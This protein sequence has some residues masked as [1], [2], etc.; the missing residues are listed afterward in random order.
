MKEIKFENLKESIYEHTLDNGL[1]IYFYNT[2]N[3]ARHYVSITTRYGSINNKYEINKNNEVSSYETVDG[4][5]HFLEH[6]L[7]ESS[8][9]EDVFTKFTKNGAGCNAYTSY[10]R[11]NYN[12]EGVDHIKENLK[13]LLDFV[14]EPHFT[15]EN[16]AKER[17][18]IEQEIGMKQDDIDTDMYFKLLKN[19]L[20]SSKEK[21]SGLGT[22]DDLNKI[23]KELLYEIYDTFYH[24]K[25][26]FIIIA[27][28]VEPTT[29]LSYVEEIMST[30]KFNDYNETKY[31]YPNE[32]DTVV[33]NI[34]EFDLE[35]PM[36]KLLYGI[37]IPNTLFDIEKYLV[38][39]YINILLDCLF[40]DTSDF[41]HELKDSNIISNELE[42]FRVNTHSHVILA[43]GTST[44][45]VKE[46]IDSI[47]THLS[48]IN[49]T[50]E[51]FDRKIKV[52]ISNT[53]NIFEDAA[54][55]ENYI[56]N[57]IIYYDRLFN[58]PIEILNSLNYNEFM[59]FIN[60]I[61]FDNTSVVVVR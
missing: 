1:R 29:V 41:F 59:N 38:N 31:I 52:R 44:E 33:T 35:L 43:V 3:K 42:Y 19:M 13:L 45:K 32:L 37:K 22:M 11:T 57:S 15:D 6:K 48:N 27:S 18:I 60:K 39:N 30:K 28:N 9:N 24:P 47:K 61:K 20:H 51:E 50:K 14:F 53:V 10:D 36:P 34:S 21:D 56:N 5:A 46:L 2:K 26:M 12:F 7:F 58:N 55:V 54:R 17:G 49:I 23:S 16:V 8:D 40:S 25:N 4:V